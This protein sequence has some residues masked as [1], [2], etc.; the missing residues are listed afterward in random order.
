MTQRDPPTQRRPSAT[1]PLDPM[2]PVPSVQL[3]DRQTAFV[4]RQAGE[5][6]SSTD[7]GVDISRRLRVFIG[8]AMGAFFVGA[9]IAVV[10]LTLG[11]RADHAVVYLLLCLGLNLVCG[12]VLWVLQ[13]VSLRAAQQIQIGAVLVVGGAAAM[14]AAEILIAPRQDPNLRM[15]LSGIGVW[16]LLFPLIVPSSLRLA[17]LTSVG[18]ATTLPIVYVAGRLVGLPAWPVP[19]LVDWVLPVYACAGLAVC[20][21]WSVG[22]L[23][24]ALADARRELKE[25]GRYRLLEK[26]GQGGM[27]EVWVGEHR[28]LPRKVAIKFVRQ[29][30]D[31]GNHD[32]LAD[33]FDAEAYAIAQLSSPHTVRLF[34][35]GIS[36]AGERYFVMELL[37][38]LTVADIMETSGPQPL[39]RVVTILMHVCRSLEEAHAKQ[40]V[41]RDIKP[42]NV[43]VSL[44]PGS[45]DHVTVLDFGLVSGASFAA[46]GRVADDGS[47]I[48]GT[49]GFIPLN[50]SLAS[51]QWM[52]VQIFTRLVASRGV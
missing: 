44:I 5:A 39:A 48:Y 8:V 21:A 30:P 46:S 36:D 3:T 19:T 45:G 31:L 15:G 43:M 49:V 4:G 11:R 27:G 16:L 40:L 9:I 23:T 13:R 12:C 51:A 7:G 6:S 38:G 41:H 18:A 47:H 52:V 25:I 32:E 42:G 33:R 37:A 10:A 20:S 1:V 35:Y 34:D 14:A 26:L 24:R 29:R 22:R 28:L 2:R 17:A 50:R